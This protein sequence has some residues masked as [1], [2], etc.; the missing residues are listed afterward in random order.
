MASFTIAV[1]GTLIRKMPRAP[2]GIREVSPHA[3]LI[4][5]M[6]YYL[7]VFSHPIRASIFIR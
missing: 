4:E 7:Y 1:N 5:F 2:M 3:I 6:L